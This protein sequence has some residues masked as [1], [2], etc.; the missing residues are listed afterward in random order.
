M[1]YVSEKN[2]HLSEFVTTIKSTPELQVI[3]DSIQKD[4]SLLNQDSNMMDLS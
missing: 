1:C 4:S 2:P 3:F